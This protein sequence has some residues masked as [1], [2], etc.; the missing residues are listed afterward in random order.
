MALEHT[1][2]SEEIAKN[3]NSKTAKRIGEL[4]AVTNVIKRWDKAN[5][6][7]F[8]GIQKHI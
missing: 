7:S 1:K 3:F 4:S 8:R 5:N 6:V 2:L